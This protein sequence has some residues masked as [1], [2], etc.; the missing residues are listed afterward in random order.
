MNIQLIVQ[1]SQTGERKDI[2]ELVQ[3]VAWTT[4]LEGTAGQLSFT[5]IPSNYNFPSGSVVWFSA[6]NKADIFRG[7]IFTT[8]L[9]KTRTLN[10]L[11]YDQLR[12]L[13]NVD[14]YV[15]K[16]MAAHQIFEKICK[17][18]Q[19]NYEIAAQVDYICAPATRDNRALSEMIQLALDETFAKTGEYLFMRDDFGT[20]VL[21]NL[22]N[23][24]R[25]YLLDKDILNL[26]FSYSR[27]ID[28]NV[29]NRIKLVRSEKQGSQTQ[30]SFKQDTANVARWGVL[31]HYEVISAEGSQ[32]DLDDRAQKL[33][34]LKNK[35]VERLSFTTEGK[36]D[37]F[38]GCGLYVNLDE[39]AQNKVNKFCIITSAKHTFKNQEHTMNIE[40]AL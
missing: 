11:A 9:T 29:A 12:Y 34:D 28:E 4:T 10:V 30:V 8:S 15:F 13:K 2:S 17:D 39:I 40:V 24:K 35:P 20:L 22:M 25:R 33:L 31:Q 3:E 36:L 38:A 23:Y 19:L 37:V 32:A 21:D 18:L 7:Y 14:T 27:S 1:D 26:D 16:N 6:P 5:L